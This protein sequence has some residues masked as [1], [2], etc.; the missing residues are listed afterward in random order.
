MRLGLLTVALLATLACNDNYLSSGECLGCR[1]VSAVV[2]GRVT[3]L[4]GTPVSRADVILTGLRSGCRAPEQYF[5]D[6]S[7]AADQT[8]AL[9]FYRTVSEEANPTPQYGCIRLVVTAPAGSGLRD[10]IVYGGNVRLGMVP[11][12]SATV[13]VVLRA[14]SQ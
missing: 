3:T 2:T 10:T 8:D 11:P 13:N 1:S 9:G 7:Q 6:P 14:V 5:S 4:D 12:D